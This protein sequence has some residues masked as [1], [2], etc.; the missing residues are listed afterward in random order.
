V[1]YVLALA[2]GLINIINASNV[3]NTHS[4]GFT[5]YLNNDQNSVK[6]L[7]VSNFYG[8]GLIDGGKSRILN[9]KGDAF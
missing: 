1:P 8:T 3:I 6:S 4:S 9:K 7:T 2:N 5:F